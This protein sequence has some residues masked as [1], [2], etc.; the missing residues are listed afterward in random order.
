[1][2]EPRF[3]DSSSRGTRS[4]VSRPPV[5]AIGSLLLR[6]PGVPAAAGVCTK[7]HAATHDASGPDTP[8]D[9]DELKDYDGVRHVGP[10]ALPMEN[11]G[12]GPPNDIVERYRGPLPTGI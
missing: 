9:N 1:M 8:H 4:C 3:R 7:H 12:A 2:K 5:R 11:H 10:Q 6:S